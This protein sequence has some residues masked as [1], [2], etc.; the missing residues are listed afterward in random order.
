MQW[1]QGG[2]LLEALEDGDSYG[3]GVSTKGLC[4]PFLLI[5]TLVGIADLG[6]VLLNLP[7]TGFLMPLL[8]CTDFGLQEKEAISGWTSPFLSYTSFN[9]S[10]RS[11]L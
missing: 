11:V 2:R 6:A 10:E 9:G 8:L 7:G 4:L 3:F 5:T 1:A